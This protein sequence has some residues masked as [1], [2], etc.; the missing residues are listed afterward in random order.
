M[1]S[2]QICNNSVMLLRQYEPKSL[3]NVVE[4]VPQRI[5]AVL[6]AKGDPSQHSQSVPN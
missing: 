5:K 4:S 2:Q 6:K 3:R 1:W